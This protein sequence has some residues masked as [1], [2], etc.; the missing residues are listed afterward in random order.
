MSDE[1][2][3][4]YVGFGHNEH[5]HQATLESKHWLPGKLWVTQIHW[6][7]RMGSWMSGRDFIIISKL[8]NGW[9]PHGYQVKAGTR[10]EVHKG[11]F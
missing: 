7:G 1:E 6:K 10:Q 2:L 5:K 9:P 4:L 3:C 8:L 11:L